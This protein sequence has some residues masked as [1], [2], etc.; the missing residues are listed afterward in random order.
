MKCEWSTEFAAVD[1]EVEVMQNGVKNKIDV[2][3]VLSVV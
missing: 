3:M 1:L 2:L